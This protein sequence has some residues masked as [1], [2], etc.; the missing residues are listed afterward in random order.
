MWWKAKLVKAL[1]NSGKVKILTD[2]LKAP[3]GEDPFHEPSFQ[4]RK[5]L[6]GEDFSD[7]SFAQVIIPEKVWSARPWL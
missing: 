3:L 5:F 4:R 7:L 2:F 1:P 6:L